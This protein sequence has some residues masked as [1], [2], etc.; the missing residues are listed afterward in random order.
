MPILI[1][2][3]LSTASLERSK[4]FQLLIENK[5]YLKTSDIT[6][7]LNT[8]APTA[9]RIMTELKAVGLVSTHGE[10]DETYHDLDMQITLNDD[11]KWFLSSEFQRLKRGDT[12]RQITLNDDDEKDEKENH[13]CLLYTSDAADD[14]Q[15]VD[16]GGRR[17]IKKKN[18]F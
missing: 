16:L 1:Q 14:M 18:F 12:S 2:V 9:R 13:P 15:C 6:D 17:I 11:F 8:T 5:G 7:L 4:I 3:V 10:D